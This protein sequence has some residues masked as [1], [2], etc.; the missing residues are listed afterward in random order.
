MFNLYYIF[1]TLTQKLLL[2]AFLDLR[3]YNFQKYK[4]LKLLNKLSKLKKKCIIINT[5]GTK[6]HCINYKEIEKVYLDE[7][8]FLCYF[9]IVFPY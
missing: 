6:L 2:L 1:E 4:N 8:V 7:I 3:I 9:L 5:I